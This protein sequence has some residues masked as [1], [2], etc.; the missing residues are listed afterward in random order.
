[1]KYRANLN[2]SSSISGGAGSISN[3][4]IQTCRICKENGFPHESI[5]FKPSKGRILSD[6]T[7][8]VTQWSV[9]DYFKSWQ[10]HRHRY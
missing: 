7:T 8:Q 10:H 1:M 5:V 2:L 9:Y 3:D 4:K 6:G